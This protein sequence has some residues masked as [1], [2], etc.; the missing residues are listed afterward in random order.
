MLGSFT[1]SPTLTRTY[2]LNEYLTA[3][4]CARAPAR[5]LTHASIGTGTADTG[6]DMAQYILSADK[7]YSLEF[8]PR[9]DG[10]AL[11]AW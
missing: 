9:E 2:L 4:T 11:D 5:V 1:L 6:K 7:E 10:V 8:Y 3:P